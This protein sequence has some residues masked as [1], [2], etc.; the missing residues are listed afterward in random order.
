[1]SMYTPVPS[2]A[3]E[4]ISAIPFRPVSS[5]LGHNIITAAPM[6]G[7]KM[8]R[9]RTQWSN[10][11]IRLLGEGHERRA[12]HDESGEE[13]G[14]VLLDTTGLHHTEAGAGLLGRE[15][16]A[17]HRP[18]DDLL[19]DDLIGEPGDMTSG[20]AH[21]VHHCVD[22]V[23]VDPVGEPGD[24][25]LD[26]TDDTIGVQV[27]EVVLVEQQRLAGVGRLVAFA[28]LVQEPE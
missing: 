8:A 14:G 27:V 4:V 12:E 7:R 26:A 22:D 5:S 20:H 11:F 9:E 13:D 2:V 1:M 28:E 3:S 17:V 21:S 23:L 18:V 19:V 16:R 6:T 15:S 24:R 10:P 25:T